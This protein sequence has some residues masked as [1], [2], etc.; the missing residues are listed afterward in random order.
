MNFK[1]GRND[2]CWCGSG[3]KFKLCHWPD[4]GNQIKTE[5]TTFGSFGASVR[6]ESLFATPKKDIGKLLSMIKEQKTSGTRIWPSRTLHSI[7]DKPEIEIRRFLVDICAKLVDENWCGRSEMC[8]YFA[9]LVRHGLNFLKQPAQVHVGKATYF[10]HE[11]QDIKFEWDHAWVVSEGQL[12][13]GN[14]DSMLENP[15]VP[16]GIAPTPY[17]GPIETTPKDRKFHSNRILDSSQDI[18]ELDEKEITRWKQ[19]LEVEI[20]EKILSLGIVH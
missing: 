18:I 9:V 6:M 4:Q 12:I 19:Q 16:I 20:Q 2:Q 15:M 8:I 7:G 13:D 14:I 17:W 11:N 10:T 5:W 3:K 1:T